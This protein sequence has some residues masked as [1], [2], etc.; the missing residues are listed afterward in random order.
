MIC[1]GLFFAV[2][3]FGQTNFLKGEDLFLRNKPGEAV[4]FLENAL[5]DDPANITACLYLGVAYE[6]LQK[7]DEAIAVYRRGLPGAGNFS[8]NIANNLGNV[9]FQKG[10]MEMA[11]QFF[12]QAIGFNPV[13]SRAYL[14]RANTRIKAGNLRTAVADYEQYLGLEPRS[15][16]RAEIEK[17]MAL[18]R[19]E[20]AAEERKRLLA[21]EEERRIAEERKKLLDSVSA[22]LQSAADASQGI[23]SG[24]ESMENYDGEFELH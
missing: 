14:G 10:D 23:S 9:Y 7:T 18:I 6:Q 2:F 5:I 20:F 22:S 8:A 21:L 3:C 13:Y 15:A 4:V 17:L 16:Q 19:S 24:A 11:E 1:A 12:S